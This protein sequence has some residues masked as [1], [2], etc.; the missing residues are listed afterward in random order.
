M[1][2]E[3][4]YRLEYRGDDDIYSDFFSSEEEAIFEVSSFKNDILEHYADEDGLEVGSEIILHEINIKEVED[5]DFYSDTTILST[6]EID[7]LETEEARMDNL[8]T[9]DDHICDWE[10]SKRMKEVVQYPILAVERD[11][12]IIIRIPDFNG[13]TQAKE[14]HE[15]IPMAKD[16]I[17]LAILDNIV[18]NTDIPKPSN[19]WEIKGEYSDYAKG[20]VKV[21][22]QKLKKLAEKEK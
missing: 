6:W 16:Y 19:I 9:S 1:K 4:L 21:D 8:I 12:H 11:D 17:E 15:I 14:L 3:K 7:L 2:V 20:I 22:L 5:I 10:D 18:D 13:M